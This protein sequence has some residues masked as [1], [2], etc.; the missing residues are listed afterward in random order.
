MRGILA[1][2]QKRGFVNSWTNQQCVFNAQEKS[3]AI[4]QPGR[5]FNQDSEGFLLGIESTFIAITVF[6][7]PDRENKKSNRLDLRSA[8][9]TLYEFSAR[10]KDELED[11]IA[12]FIEGDVSEGKLYDHPKY[13]S[14][15]DLSYLRL[16]HNHVEKQLDHAYKTRD[17]KAINALQP[18]LERLTKIKTDAEEIQ[19][20]LSENS[21]SSRSRS[22]SDLEKE[23][24]ESREAIAE[25]ANLI[26]S[27]RQAKVG[28]ARWVQ[29]MK[30][31]EIDYS[32]LELLTEQLGK[33][34]FGMVCKGRC[35]GMDVAIKI[36]PS[37][38]TEKERRM[39]H[40][41]LQAETRAFSRLNHP[42][43]ISMLHV[44]IDNPSHPCL[45]LEL[46]E[47]GS[48]WGVLQQDPSIAMWQRL[49]FACDIASGM[50]MIHYKGI[51]HHDLKPENCLVSESMVVKISDLGT[52]TGIGT[53]FATAATSAGGVGGTLNYSAPEKL[54]YTEGLRDKPEVDVYAFAITLLEILTGSRVWEG[55]SKADVQALVL[56]GKRPPIPPNVDQ[57]FPPLRELI[58]RCWARQPTKRPPF[59]EILR[60]LQKVGAT[61]NGSATN[62]TV[63][64]ITLVAST[65][66]KS[67]DGDSVMGY[68]E[69]MCKI[70]PHLLLG[71]TPAQICGRGS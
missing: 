67:L 18:Q 6:R 60:E 32:E 11:W 19:G 58:V 59:S 9:G 3:F 40:K 34:S 21:S 35:L 20:R 37:A 8:E 56:A 12:A 16:R 57:A 42:N 53:T 5:S 63:T 22:F 23:K 52:A 45:V 33:G 71:Y 41:M 27:V 47:R 30:T 51:V 36:L 25:L 44:S 68:I 65:A 1:C 29:K 64:T 24:K 39:V 26:D 17:Q 4:L 14:E 48:L 15:W 10:S 50:S 54:L 66:A 69:A 43:I 70:H 46:A 13:E 55:K 62:A 31:W 2:K 7:I 28:S 49:R 61:N 38:N